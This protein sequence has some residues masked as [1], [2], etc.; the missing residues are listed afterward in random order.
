MAHLDLDISDMKPSAM[1][2]YDIAQEHGRGV[3]CSGWA[4]G[5]AIGQGRL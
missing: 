4:Q 5:C 3:E 1:V 2:R